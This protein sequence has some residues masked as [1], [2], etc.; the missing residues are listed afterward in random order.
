MYK[1]TFSKILICGFILGLVGISFLFITVGN[2]PPEEE[3]DKTFGGGNDGEGHYVQSTIDGGYII[4]GGAKSF[5][6]IL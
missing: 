4:T 1:R 2:T 3:W 6:G 5:G